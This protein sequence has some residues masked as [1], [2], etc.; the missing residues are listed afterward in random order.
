MNKSDL[1]RLRKINCACE[2]NT[3]CEEFSEEG[4]TEECRE[5]CP[6]FCKMWDELLKLLGA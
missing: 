6:G 5:C 2:D 1:L 3:V 4:L